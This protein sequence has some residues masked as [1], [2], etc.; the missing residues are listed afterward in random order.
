MLLDINA[1]VGHWPFMQRR[2]N[3]CEALLGRMN[4]FGVDVSAISNLNGIFYKNTQSANEELYNEIRSDRRFSERFIPFAVINPI[5]AG[6]RDDL[7]VCVKKMG[8]KGVR[9]YPKYHDYE[10]TDPSLVELVKRV[11]DHGL[12]VAFKIRMIDSRIRSWM[13]IPFVV[14]TPRPEWTLNN[15]VPIVRAVPDAK[16][17][18]LNV[19]NNIRLNDEDMALF[20]KTEVVFDTSGRQVNSLPDLLK[21]YGREKFAF[22]THSPILDYLTGLLRIEALRESEADAETKEVLRSG[23]AK[24]ILGI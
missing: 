24:R 17:L 10:I 18:I 9:L 15:I 2:Y 21:S 11:R 8:M 23:N 13:D 3:T 16:Y 4:K 22:G 5:Y 1:Y 12:P 7:E 19:A 6:W 14:G 20:S